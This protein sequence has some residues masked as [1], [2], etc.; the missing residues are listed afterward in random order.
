MQS[1]FC[2]P[3]VHCKA[4]MQTKR[5]PHVALSSARGSGNVDNL[6][7]AS[8]QVKQTLPYQETLS[9]D[10]ARSTHYLRHVRLQQQLLKPGQPSYSQQGED[11]MQTI[12]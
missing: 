7:R 5:T 1:F 3:V 6:A 11:R 10:L 4:K 9:L 8:T 12:L 2:L